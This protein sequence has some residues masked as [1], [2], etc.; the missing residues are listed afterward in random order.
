[1]TLYGIDVSN[2]QAG[3]DLRQVATEGFSWVEAKVSEGDYYQDPTWPGFL[4]E[5]QQIGLPIIGYHFAVAACP[6]AA[7]AQ[8]WLANGGP[9]VCMID[10]ESGA[11]SI[12]D[13]RALVQAFNNAG[14]TVALSYIPQWYWQE[15][16]SPDLSQVP[17][18][19][20]S[21]YP[22]SFA[23]YASTL[24]E[25]NGGDA[26]EGWTSYGNATPAIWQ[27]TDQA[28]VAGMH[29]DANAF[30]GSSSELAALLS[31]GDMTPQQA[32][33]L[34]DIRAQLCGSGAEE[35]GFPGWPE[36][37]QNPDGSNRTPVDA[38]AALITMVDQ[39]QTAVAALNGAQS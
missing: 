30:R 9:D 23:G 13:Y 33:Q 36:L 15:I 28:L 11:G 3:I 22:T 26:G 17:G 7:Q 16:G 1:M 8:T 31:G 25:N 12:A 5:A 32:Q 39:L 10:F 35:S 19:V 27:F 37:G 24:Y 21:S 2:Y 4:A 20:S 34:S 14:V 18:L 29:V 38:I 6:A